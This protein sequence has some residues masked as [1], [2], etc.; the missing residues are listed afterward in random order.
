MPTNHLDR[1]A[2][3]TWLQP[4]Y[5]TRYGKPRDRPKM[6]RKAKKAFRRKWGWPVYAARFEIDLTGWLAAIDAAR[7][8]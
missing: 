8:E 7:E 5:G 1:E 4:N 6:S 3:V 2:R